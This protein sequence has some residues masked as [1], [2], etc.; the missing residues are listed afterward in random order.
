MADKLEPSPHLYAEDELRHL[1][2]R[3]VQR[4]TRYQDFL[5]LCLIRVTSAEPSSPQVRGAIAR[6][7]AE[8]LRSSDLVGSIAEDIAVLLVH[9]PDTDAIMIADRIRERVYR[10]S[11]PA[12]AGAVTVRIG[13]ACFPVDGTSDDALL[14]HA[15]ARLE[16]SA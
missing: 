5:S 3:E 8:M 2:A 13:L 9:T 11:P 6:Q 4:S 16:A 12:P 15:Q 7:V 10:P 14:A 1:L